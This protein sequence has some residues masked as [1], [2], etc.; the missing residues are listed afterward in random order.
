MDAPI[1][2]FTVD[3]YF[4]RCPDRKPYLISVDVQHGHRDVVAN[5]QGIVRMSGQDEHVDSLIALK[6]WYVVACPRTMPTRMRLVNVL[7]ARGRGC[8]C[9]EAC[10]V[11]PRRFVLGT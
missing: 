1:N 11:C 7:R 4:T 9:A 10:M 2:F 3:R 5:P 8:V 6:R